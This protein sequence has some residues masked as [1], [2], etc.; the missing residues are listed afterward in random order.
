MSTYTF[1]TAVLWFSLTG[2]L[3]TVVYIVAVLWDY[4]TDRAAEEEF[5]AAHPEHPANAAR[6]RHP[7]NG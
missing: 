2:A 7:S 4:L 3:L 1:W 5:L 6:R